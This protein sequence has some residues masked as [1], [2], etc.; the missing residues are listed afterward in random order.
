MNCLY[1]TCRLT[2]IPDGCSATRNLSSDYGGQSRL[3]SLNV[4]TSPEGYDVTAL[5]HGSATLTPTHLN[6]LILSQGFQSLASI[7]FAQ[8]PSVA[9]YF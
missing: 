5:F 9:H 8:T 3:L 2:L 1:S 7:S 4:S 6:C